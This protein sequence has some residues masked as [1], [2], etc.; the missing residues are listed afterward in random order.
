MNLKKCIKGHFYDADKS[1]SCPLCGEQ[2]LVQE[3]DTTVYL[4]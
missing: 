1:S 3:D 4:K 2:E